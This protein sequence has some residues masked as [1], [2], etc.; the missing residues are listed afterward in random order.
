MKSMAGVYLKD[1]PDAPDEAGETMCLF[2][3]IFPNK[4]SIYYMKT[5][6]EKE[7]W[8]HGIKEAVGYSSL[9]DFYDLGTTLG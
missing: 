9:N 5:K 3:L 2:M 7:K 4:R 1:E 8:I 6:E